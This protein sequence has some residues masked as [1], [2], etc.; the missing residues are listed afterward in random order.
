MGPSAIDSEIRSLSP[1]LGGSTHLLSQFLTSISVVLE[2]KRNYELVQAY[3][4]LFLK[5]HG[6]SLIE[7]HELCT[8]TEKVSGVLK[9]SWSTLQ[10]NFES[11]L[12]L[13]SFFMNAVI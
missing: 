9:D 11:T 13:V 6:S 8:Q 10:T 12:C 5:I 1:Y 4:G 7:K 3:L 2:S